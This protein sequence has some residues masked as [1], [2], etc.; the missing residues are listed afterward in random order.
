MN[1]VIYKLVDRK[2]NWRK[3][4][5]NYEQ[6][7]TESEWNGK[8][9]ISLKVKLIFAMGFLSMKTFLMHDDVVNQQWQKLFN[10]KINW[11]HDLLGSETKI[12]D[13]GK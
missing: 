12:L 8:F 13:D 5:M 9:D 10:Q 2:K 6:R 1:F 11:I 4:G 3:N 7:L